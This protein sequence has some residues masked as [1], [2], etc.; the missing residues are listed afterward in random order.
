MRKA[1]L[2]F[3]PECESSN[4]AWSIAIAGAQRNTEAENW[5]RSL[6]STPKASSPVVVASDSLV[7]QVADVKEKARLEELGKLQARDEH[8]AEKEPKTMSRKDLIFVH[9]S[10]APTIAPDQNTP[11][12]ATVGAA[13]DRPSVRRTWRDVA[14]HYMV[15]VFNAGQYT[16]AKAFYKALEAKAGKDSPFDAGTG[17]NRGSLVVRELSETVTLKTVQNTWKEFKLSCRKA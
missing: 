5:Q 11:S 15:C 7:P 3:D 17:A 2:A 14:W 8:A 6:A 12:P 13:R 9:P 16:T 1:A 4:E 10:A